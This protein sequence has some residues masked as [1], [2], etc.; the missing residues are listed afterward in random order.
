MQ[1]CASGRVFCDNAVQCQPRCCTSGVCLASLGPPAE[2]MKQVLAAHGCAPMHTRSSARA[3]LCYER[4]R[5]QREHVHNRI[6]SGG[7]AAAPAALR[8]SFVAQAKR[9]ACSGGAPTLET[10]VRAP[11]VSVR[12]R[13][14]GA[15]VRTFACARVH[16]HALWPMCF[17]GGCLHCVHVYTLGLIDCRLQ[18]FLTVP[19]NKKAL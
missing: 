3:H 9:R 6:Q 4:A 5:I 16:S 15:P 11:F 13:R 1:P 7:S 10:V 8:L 12:A 17:C 19:G 14:E 18:G 2:Q